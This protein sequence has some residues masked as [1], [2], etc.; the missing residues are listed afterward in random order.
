M[1][2]KATQKLSKLSQIDLAYIMRGG[3]W[4]SVGHLFISLTSFFVAYIFANYIEKDVYGTYKFVFSLVAIITAFTLTGMGDAVTQSTASGNQKSLQTG[5]RMMLRWSIIPIGISLAVCTYYLWKGNVVLGVSV[6]LVTFLTCIFQSAVLY[7]NFLVGIKS[8]KE[9]SAISVFQA[10]IPNIVLVIILLFFTQENLILIVSVFTG[11]NVLTGLVLYFYIKKK[12]AISSND[13]KDEDISVYAKQLSV[14]NIISR[15]ANNIDKVIVFHLLGA[16]QTAIYSITLIIPEQIKVLVKQ[17]ATMSTPKF[18][19][20]PVEQIKNNFFRKQLLLGLVIL[21]I[22]ACYIFVAPVLYKILFPLYS[23][24]VL[25]SQIFAL[26]LL[27]TPLLIS[28]SFLKA[29]KKTK[30]LYQFTFISNIT[31]LIVLCFGA[32]YWGLI[33]VIVARVI[34]R[35]LHLLFIS[36]L[37]HRL[38]RKV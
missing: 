8:F 5:F 34:T 11:A 12:Y 30:E 13:H 2:K 19:K 35:F 37:T 27:A 4:M 18:A 22:V 26:S 15:I 3:F 14:M 23:D 6:L 1:I 17:I 36:L 20:R 7:K 31:G 29:H 9:H 21:G 16:T 33:G 32:F 24:S 28:Q 25:Y 10:I 38:F